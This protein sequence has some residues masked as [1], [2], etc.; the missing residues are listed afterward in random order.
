MN[1]FARMDFLMAVPNLLIL[2]VKKVFGLQGRRNEDWFNVIMIR[3]RNDMNI[4]IIP[5]KYVSKY[6]HC[7]MMKRNVKNMP[8]FPAETDLK[9][10]WVNVCQQRKKGYFFC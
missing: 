6:W 5:L 1:A 10:V 9:I 4:L 7:Y 3:Q 8:C 2:G